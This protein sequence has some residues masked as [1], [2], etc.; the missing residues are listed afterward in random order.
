MLDKR[1]KAF[2]LRYRPRHNNQL[3]SLQDTVLW[4]LELDCVVDVCARKVF[5]ALVRLFPAAVL[6]R[7]RVL[8]RT[9]TNEATDLALVCF[10]YTL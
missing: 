2:V 1:Y 6:A 8:A 4:L 9:G 5:S 10:P 3:V 7:V